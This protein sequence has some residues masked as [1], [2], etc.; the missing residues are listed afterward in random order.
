MLVEFLKPV[1]TAKGENCE[2]SRRRFFLFNV[3]SIKI[4]PGFITTRLNHFGKSIKNV[5]NR[6]LAS[7]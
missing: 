2:A 7:L 5:L 1:K 4:D 6:F 3:I